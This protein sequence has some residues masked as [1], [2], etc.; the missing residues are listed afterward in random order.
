MP[1]NS[2]RQP[3]AVDT[4][5]MNHVSGPS[6]AAKSRDLNTRDGQDGRPIS[7][8]ESD[9]RPAPTD[10]ETF[11]VHEAFVFCNHLGAG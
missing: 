8:S 4:M 7:S 2:D 3:A 10:T 11:P 9:L 6:L 5:S 1:V